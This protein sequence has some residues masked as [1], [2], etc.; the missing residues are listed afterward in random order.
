MIYEYSRCNNNLSNNFTV[1]WEQ[2]FGEKLVDSVSKAMKQ[3]TDIVSK[4]VKQNKTNT[5]KN[6][7]FKL[8]RLL[9][10]EVKIN[11]SGVTGYVTD[12]TSNGHFLRIYC[13]SSFDFVIKHDLTL[14]TEDGDELTFDEYVEMYYGD[15]L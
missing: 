10:C 2:V 5:V 6:D 7:T 11:Y 12:I 4:T 13:G 9:G 8:E 14:F 15:S 3:N 1:T